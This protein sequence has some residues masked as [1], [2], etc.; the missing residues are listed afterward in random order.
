MCRQDFE[1]VADYGPS[2]QVCRLE[3]PGVTNF[4][5][6]APPGIV[7]NKQV[8]E[9]LSELVPSSMRGKELGRFM[10]QMGL[11]TISVIEY[12]RVTIT[13]PQDPDHPGSRTAVIV[14]F[15]NE[16]CRTAADH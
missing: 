2:Y 3:L 8:D 1:I 14:T 4:A 12:E 6:N 5:G 9:V 13:E 16:S 15:K 7:T 10:E 11:L